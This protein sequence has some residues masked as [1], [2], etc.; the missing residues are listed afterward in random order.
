MR[1]A[2][3]NLA[4][5]LADL[6]GPEAGVASVA[7]VECSET[8]D[9][10]CH[11]SSTVPDFTSFNPGYACLLAKAKRLMVVVTLYAQRPTFPLL[12]SQLA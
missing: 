11:T 9:R 4:D 7:R 6:V 2:P 10:R 8:R 3:T 12:G 5:L 1:Y